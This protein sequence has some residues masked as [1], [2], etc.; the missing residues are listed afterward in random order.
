MKRRLITKREIIMKR[1]NITKKSFTIKSK[2]LLKKV[3]TQ[4][5]S[6]RQLKMRP[7][8]RHCRKKAKSNIQRLQKVTLQVDSSYSSNLKVLKMSIKSNKKQRWQAKDERYRHNHANWK[9]SRIKSN[10]RLIH[11]D[12]VIKCLDSCLMNLLKC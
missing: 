2:N 8:L 9:F 4:T 11:L 12:R 10:Q 6:M 7:M 5:R 3:K 1:Q